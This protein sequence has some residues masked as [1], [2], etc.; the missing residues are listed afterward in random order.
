LQR[1]ISGEVRGDGD[2]SADDSTGGGRIPDRSITTL[3]METKSRWRVDS[4][5]EGVPHPPDTRRPPSEDRA[6]RPCCPLGGAGPLSSPQYR[7]GRRRA[8]CR[9]GGLFRHAVHLIAAGENP[10]EDDETIRV[11]GDGRAIELTRCAQIIV[12]GDHCRDMD[13]YGGTRSTVYLASD[14]D[15]IYAPTIPATRAARQ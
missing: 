12:A 6:T 15:A 8:E 2:D 4:S 3:L 11:A 9:A 7:R 14:I 5:E 13:R 1:L 10:T